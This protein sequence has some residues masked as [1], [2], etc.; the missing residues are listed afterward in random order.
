MRLSA[1]F[2]KV[3][4]VFS[5]FVVGVL[6]VT[7]PTLTPASATGLSCS[8]YVA[9][10]TGNTVSVIDAATNTVT[11]TIPVGAEPNGVAVSSTGNVYVTN[12]SGNTVSVV[13]AAT[14][15]VTASIAVG[16]EPSGVAVSPTGEV[17]VTDQ[18]GNSVSVIDGAT[19]TVVST[20]QVV[21]APSSVAV[22]PSGTVYVTNSANDTVAVID[23]ATNTVT[24]TISVAAGVGYVAVSPSGTV[25]VTS[26]LSRVSVI[27]PVGNTV[28]E[29][30][31]AG[32]ITSGIA[33]SPSGTVYVADL[34]DDGV[35]VIDGSTNH[36]TKTIGV[37]TSP[38]SV[39]VSP[40]GTVYVTNGA[41]DTVSVIDGSTNT[42][43]ATIPVGVTP[44]GVAVFCPTVAPGA[45][46][47]SPSQG[48]TSTT[49]FRL[50]LEGSGACPAGA[51][52]RHTFLVDGSVSLRTVQ[53]GEAG[54]LVWN[55]RDV[56]KF[57]QPLF[58][59][60]G[61]ELVQYDGFANYPDQ[62]LVGSF[63]WN[64][65]IPDGTYHLGLACTK[66]PA[67]TGQVL[68]WWSTSVTISGS[69]AYWNVGTL[70]EPRFTG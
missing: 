24:S 12:A 9:N 3:L 42:V 65:P 68:S 14:N 40:S 56:G 18:G 62:G 50:G 46:R 7:T 36:V 61:V 30:I 26:F 27:D 29:T 38:N 10:E 2:V 63:A 69:G 60:R 49:T 59:P 28:T 34:G 15:T 44:S 8:V 16:V 55:P 31:D 39:A 43:T 70:A 37:G 23:S 11:A 53:F 54:P 57:A 41:A 13:S 5:A 66:G 6:A 64:G 51:D 25:Y 19:G 1:K 67:G 47:M 17:Y 52:A 21:G 20:I 32:T 58:D 35:S 45:V 48:S 33:V 22:S 4:V